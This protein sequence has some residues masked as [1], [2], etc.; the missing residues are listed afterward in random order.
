MKMKIRHEDTMSEIGARGNE[1]RKT[2]DVRAGNRGNLEDQ[3]TENKVKTATTRT[4]AAAK[5][6]TEAARHLRQFDLAV[7]A[8]N[9][10]PEWNEYIHLDAPHKYL[11]LI[12]LKA[13]QDFL[14]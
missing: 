4:G 10:H 14:G 9:E 7:K 11:K 2:E 12:R 5:P 3:K 1:A 13:K 8:I 6:E